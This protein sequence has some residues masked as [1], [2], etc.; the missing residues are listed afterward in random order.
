M[1]DCFLQ[2]TL[3]SST[4]KKQIFFYSVVLS[5]F[6]PFCRGI[7][8]R[9]S[10]SHCSFAFLS[11]LCYFQVVPH[12][13]LIEMQG[14]PKE[15]RQH[16]FVSRVPPKP[17]SDLPGGTLPGPATSSQ[18]VDQDPPAEKVRK[19][20]PNQ[21]RPFESGRRDTWKRGRTHEPREGGLK[22]KSTSG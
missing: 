11:P 13:H 14:T 20:H 15:G 17:R 16:R 19:L 2:S 22:K 18:S 7:L 8:L 21:G 12:L 10:P 6:L 9:L 1:L 3:F 5:L 4:R